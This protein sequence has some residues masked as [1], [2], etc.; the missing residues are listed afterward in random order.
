MSIKKAIIKAKI[1]NEICELMVKSRIDNIF[2]TDNTQTLASKLAEIIASLNEKA[3]ATDV[4]S[5]INT[6]ISE[7]INGAPETYDTLK[8]LADYIASHEDVV[9]ALNN[10]IGGKADKSALE[11]LQGTVNAIKTTVDGL[12]S[13]AKKSLV[14]ETDLDAALK[15]KVN[16]AA[17]GNHSHSNKTVL[18]GINSAKVAEWDGKSK[19]YTQASQ[20]ANMTDKDLWIQTL[21]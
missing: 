17:Q 8:E 19:V 12:G 15:E 3:K 11:T 20:P 18:D 7:L 14:S 1:E 6:A 10:A 4:T 13:L 2:M 16:A 5:E 9:D 21:E